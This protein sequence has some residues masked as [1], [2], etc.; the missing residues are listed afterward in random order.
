MI[1]RIAISIISIIV[2]AP[3]AMI[4]AFA[5]YGN[6][7]PDERLVLH[8]VQIE[9][10][11]LILISIAIIFIPKIQW[12]HSLVAFVTML[13]IIGLFLYSRFSG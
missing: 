2:C 1:L 8:V 3:V 13:S 5:A 9:L 12:L 7:I 10:Y 4:V 11:F 6:G